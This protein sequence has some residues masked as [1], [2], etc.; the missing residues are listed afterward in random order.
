[1][2]T[3]DSE[4]KT[5]IVCQ[6]LLRHERTDCFEFVLE[7]YTKLRHGVPPEVIFT[8]ADKAMTAAIQEVCPLALHLYCIWHTIQNII[9]RCTSVLQGRFA[10]MLDHFKKA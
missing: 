1:M 6:A 9:K 5:R 10:E 3:V 8:D 2:V 7:Q 4:N